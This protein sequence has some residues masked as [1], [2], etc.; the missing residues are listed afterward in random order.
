MLHLHPTSGAHHAV[1][2]L[3][4][5]AESQQ[6]QQLLQV[7]L[8]SR[9]C[10]SSSAAAQV[11]QQTRDSAQLMDAAEQQEEKLRQLQQPLL[12]RQHVPLQGTARSCAGVQPAVAPPLHRLVAAAAATAA[13]CQPTW[14]LAAAQTLQLAHLC[15]PLL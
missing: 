10:Y 2:A 6:R 12:H 14:L 15:L 9:F 11:Q 4:V 3:L 5:R 7:H 13:V 1:A 8:S